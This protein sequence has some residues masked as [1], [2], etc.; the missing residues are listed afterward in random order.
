ML[1]EIKVKTVARAE[2]VDITALVQR[3]I[4]R[5]GV[6]D[7]ICIVYVPHTAAGI[8]I[9]EGAD[10]DVCTDIITQLNKMVPANPESRHM[11]ENSDSH[12]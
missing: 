1:G 4:S 8:T 11:E 10:P 6:S 12:F 9:N 5:K 2:M 3:E 7:G